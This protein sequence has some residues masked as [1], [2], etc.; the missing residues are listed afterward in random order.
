MPR[1]F[2]IQAQEALKN[3]NYA[4][5]VRFAKMQAEATNSAED[6]EKLQKAERYLS[7]Y[8][9]IQA[10]IKQEGGNSYEI[11]GTRREDTLN[12]IKRSFREKASRYHPDRA[13]IKG[14]TEAFRI[15]Q[16]AFN[17]INTEEKRIEYD[18]Q[19]KRRLFAQKNMQ[20]DLF[21]ASQCRHS[22]SGSTGGFSFSFSTGDPNSAIDYEEMFNLYNNLYRTNRAKR[23]NHT[24]SSTLSPVLAVVIL[25]VLL[26]LC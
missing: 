7:L 1:D 17:K 5:Y 19:E 23:N 25:I 14:S 15:I 6:R 26:I 2:T 8:R 18:A 20:N 4:D 24:N 3:Q 22:Y 11:L 10:I 13:P 16:D 12:E 21:T 9:E